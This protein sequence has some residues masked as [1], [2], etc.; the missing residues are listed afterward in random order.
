MSSRLIRQEAIDAFLGEAALN[1][2]FLRAR[3]KISETLL[4]TVDAS[5][6][7]AESRLDLQR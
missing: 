6:Q 7:G 4:R 3:D 2:P 5:E 1:S